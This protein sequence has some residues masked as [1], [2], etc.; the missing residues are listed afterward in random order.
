MISGM[1]PEMNTNK[2]G[3]NY[4]AKSKITFEKS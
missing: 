2:K 3:G 1:K 4:N